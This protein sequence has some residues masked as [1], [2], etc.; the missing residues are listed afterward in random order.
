MFGA[1]GNATSNGKTIQLRALDWDFDGP[2]RKYAAIIVYHP[3]DPKFGNTW[4]NIGFAGWI[5][6]ISGIN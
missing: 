2:Y 6:V 5:G 3:S 1:W 4:M